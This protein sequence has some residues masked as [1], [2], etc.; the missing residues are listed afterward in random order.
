MM[1]LSMYAYGP[2]TSYAYPP[3]PANPKVAWNPEWTARVRYRSVNSKIVGMPDMDEAMSDNG[4][5]GEPRQPAKKCGML[6]RA[7]GL[8]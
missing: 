3:R 6:Q 1:M 4:E 2:E 7:A 5:R 8:C